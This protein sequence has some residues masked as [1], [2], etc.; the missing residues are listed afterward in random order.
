MLPSSP[1]LLSIAL[2][3]ALHLL[4]HHVYFISQNFHLVLSVL[5]PIHTSPLLLFPDL[6]HLHEVPLSW[7]PEQA[8]VRSQVLRQ[9]KINSL[10]STLQEFGGDRA[11]IT[12]G[13]HENISL[14][15]SD[16]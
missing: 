16:Y 7:N 4:P 15:D 2:P 1:C 11:L 3:G 5:S 6:Y 8:G 12:V 9:V 14:I 13:L 10:R